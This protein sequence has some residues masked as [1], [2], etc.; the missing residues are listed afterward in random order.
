MNFKRVDF[1]PKAKS[2]STNQQFFQTSLKYFIWFCSPSDLFFFP[3]LH[4]SFHSFTCIHL[5]HRKI[6]SFA[7]VARTIWFH[8]CCYF[9]FLSFHLASALAFA[10]TTFAQLFTRLIPPLSPINLVSLS[11]FLCSIFQVIFLLS[12]CMHVCRLLKR[13]K[14]LPYS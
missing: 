12:P 2:L 14:F 10:C 13:S 5:K 1:F 8:P 3:S 4:A 11:S 9:S 7:C 6:R